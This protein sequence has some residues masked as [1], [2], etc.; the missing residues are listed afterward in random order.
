MALQSCPK[1]DGAMEQGFTLDLAHS[2][3]RQ[4]EWIAGAPEK[5]F[6]TGIKVKG[7]IRLPI[8]TWRCA[9]CGYLESYARSA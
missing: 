4:A 7:K 8:V 2:A 5:S 1:C 6:W 9:R 3:Y